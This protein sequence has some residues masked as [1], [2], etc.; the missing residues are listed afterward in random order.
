MMQSGTAPR[1]AVPTP[2]YAR[3]L[4]GASAELRSGWKAFC[5]GSVGFSLRKSFCNM[6]SVASSISSQNDYFTNEYLYCTNRCCSLWQK[7]TRHSAEVKPPRRGGI[8]PLAS[9]GAG[10]AK[11]EVQAFPPF[12]SATLRSQPRNHGI[13]GTRTAH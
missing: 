10:P 13:S 8:K 5:F 3:T 2:H 9:I 7:N 6:L 12:S 11:T 1:R 4:A